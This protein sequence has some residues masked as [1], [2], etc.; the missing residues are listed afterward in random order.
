MSQKCRVVS[1]QKMGFC[2]PTKSLLF[3]CLCKFSEPHAKRRQYYCDCEQTST[4]CSRHEWCILLGRS[5]VDDSCFHMQRKTKPPPDNRTVKRKRASCLSVSHHACVRSQRDSHYV[6]NAI[7]R[8]RA[9][10]VD[11]PNMMV[12]IMEHGLWV[13]IQYPHVELTRFENVGFRDWCVKV[14]WEG[15]QNQH[16]KQLRFRVVAK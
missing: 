14:I 6:C 11:V 1:F 9:W 16:V 5:F 2:F 13:A 8:S 3:Q 7:G 4:E 10:G 12:A 15:P